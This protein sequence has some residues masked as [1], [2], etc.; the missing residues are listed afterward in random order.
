MH[1]VAKENDSKL[2]DLIVATT[3]LAE[4]VAPRKGEQEV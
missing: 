2:T 4:Y 3:I 1:P